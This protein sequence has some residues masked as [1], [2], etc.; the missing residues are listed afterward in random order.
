MALEPGLDVTH[1]KVVSMLRGGS[2]RLLDAGAGDGKLSRSLARLGYDVK[3]CDIL[4]TSAFKGGVP[5]KRADLNHEWP[6]EDGSFDTVVCVEVIEHVESPWHVL[7]EARRVLKKGGRLILTTPNILNVFSRLSFLVRGTFFVFG[8]GEFR[9]GD[10]IN[11]VSW[12][13]LKII[14]DDL[15]FSIM[16][17]G[18]NKYIGFESLKKAVSLATYFFLFPV[19]RPRSKPLLLGELLIVEARKR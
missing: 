2:G 18:A 15:G 13:E 17:V 6:Y 8:P 9:K 1:S 7:R 14:L 3:A 12:H 4:P 16:A 19:L 11:P 5:Y 10:H